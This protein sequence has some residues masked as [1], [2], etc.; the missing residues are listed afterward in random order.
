MGTVA[1]TKTVKKKKNEKEE[2]MQAHT[3][4]LSMLM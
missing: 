4:V 2:A 1:K 3:S